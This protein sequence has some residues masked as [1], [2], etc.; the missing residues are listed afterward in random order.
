MHD[1]EHRRFSHAAILLSIAGRSRRVW[2]IDAETWDRVTNLFGEIDLFDGTSMELPPTLCE[3]AET[4]PDASRIEMHL[5]LSGLDGRFQEAI[6]TRPGGNG[7]VQF[8]NLLDL[9]EDAGRLYVSDA[10]YFDI[11]QYHEIS[12]TGS[13]FVTKLHGNIEPEEVCRRPVLEEYTDAGG[14]TDCGYAVLRT[15][16][17]V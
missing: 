11:D 9:E 16:T 7:N 3:W 17:S 6:T 14:R 1:N 5:K 15:D 13:Y 10:G 8:G 12:D 2:G 4:E